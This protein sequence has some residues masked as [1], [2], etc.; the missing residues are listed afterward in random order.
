MRRVVSVKVVMAKGVLA[1]MASHHS[2][3][4]LWKLGNGYKP[5]VLSKSGEKNETDFAFGQDASS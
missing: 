1:V 2:A 5:E 3:I 4:A